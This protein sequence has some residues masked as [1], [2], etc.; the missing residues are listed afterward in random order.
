MTA[1][2]LTRMSGRADPVD[3]FGEEPL[4]VLGTRQVRLH[5]DRGAAGGVDLFAGLPQG[6][7]IFRIGVHRPRGDRDGGAFRGEPLRDRLAQPRLPPVT[8]A[9]L[10][11]HFPAMSVS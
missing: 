7:L 5:G 9:T 11:A 6:P 10:P 2:L 4:T 8:S 1:A 3:N